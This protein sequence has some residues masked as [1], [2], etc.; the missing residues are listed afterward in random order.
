MAAIAAPA[1]STVFA[2]LIGDIV[3]DDYIYAYPLILME[4]TRRIQHQCRRH[5]TV[6][7]G[8]DEPVYEFA[9]IS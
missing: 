9:G 6:R 7:Q 8:A 2:D 4:L 3:T 5:S 1:A